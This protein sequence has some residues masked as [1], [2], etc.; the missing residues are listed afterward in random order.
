[1]AAAEAFHTPV[2]VNE[3]LELLEPCIKAG[4][5]IDGTVGGGGH[6]E[7]IA[8]RIKELGVNS[9]IVGL[10]LD[11]AAIRFAAERLKDF[12]CRVVDFDER[13]QRKENGN[14]KQ[15]QLPQDAMIFLVR[16][17]YVN[18]E[19]VVERLGVKPV[20]AVLMDLGVSSFQLNGERGFSFDRDGL[21]DMRFDPE[22]RGPT[23]LEILRR[24]SE[25]ELRGWLLKY[26]EERF[27]GRIAR[28]IHQHKD[29][30][31]TSRELADVVR[32]AVPGFNVRKSLARVF[33]A[34]RIVVNR[35]LENV[36]AGLEA[37]V[38]V[39]A[40]GGRLAVICYQSGEDRCFKEVYRRWKGH[41][42]G[43]KEKVETTGENG[44]QARRLR[45]LNPKPIRPCAEEVQINPRARSARLR[46]LEVVA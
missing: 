45:V 31:R 27:S 4:T 46:V 13:R 18:M 33:Q 40:P 21:L 16:T 3:V 26:G 5:V 19:E 15:N 6:T 35:E 25:Q 7:A 30:I 34:L 36:A 42:K 41:E 9:R 29:W 37:A 38:R 1:M 12:G 44:E 43:R 39:L 32:S 23:A 8:C 24:A 14:E 22:G 10:D 2:L 11:P 28:K 20:T 17:S